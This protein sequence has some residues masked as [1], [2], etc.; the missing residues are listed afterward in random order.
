[1]QITTHKQMSGCWVS[2]PPTASKSNPYGEMFLPS[3]LSQLATSLST[4]PPHA[5]ISLPYTVMGLTSTIQFPNGTTRLTLNDKWWTTEESVWIVVFQKIYY[6][7][8]TCMRF[9][10]MIKN[11]IHK[12]KFIK[13]DN[14]N[15]GSEGLLR[16][17]LT[18]FHDLFLTNCCS[19]YTASA[20]LT[21]AAMANK[22]SRC[23]AVQLTASMLWPIKFPLLPL[24][25]ANLLTKF[26]LFSLIKSHPQHLLTLRGSGSFKSHIRFILFGYYSIFSGMDTPQTYRLRIPNSE[27]R[28]PTILFLFFLFFFLGTLDGRQ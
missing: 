4:L 27:N 21:V 24:L 19:R 1:M 15:K 26:L 28:G 16:A 14:P 9:K 18:F 6:S 5:Q 25:P 11:Y 8:L 17:C 12:K 3:G 23:H 13:N 20:N 22:F 10:K 2:D 7:K